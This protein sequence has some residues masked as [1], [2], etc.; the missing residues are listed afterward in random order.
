MSDRPW[1]KYLGLPYRP[2]ADP[3]HGRASD[4]IRLVI[5]TLELGGYDP[6]PVR[7]EWYEHLCRGE[8]DAVV[9]D[10]FALT[11]QTSGPEDYA[12]TLLPAGDFSI[13]IVV[14]GGLLS[15]RPG[16]GVTWV[17]VANLPPRNYRRL[18]AHA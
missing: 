11:E 10:W 14:D 17:P 6:P 12:M 4:C 5:R 8:I 16:P 15:V 1:A 3:E 9:A 2:G 13:G 18:I 7:R